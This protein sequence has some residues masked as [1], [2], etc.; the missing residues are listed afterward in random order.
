MSGAGGL[1]AAVRALEELRARGRPPDHRDARALLLELG[2][3]L[4]AAP[5]GAAELELEHARRATEALGEAW[6][7]AALEELALASTE[8]VRSVD[9]RYLDLPNYDFEYTLAARE[10]L[11][12]RLVAAKALGLAPGNR[13][14]RK[15]ERADALL[16]RRLE[17]LERP[18]G[19]R[20][21]GSRGK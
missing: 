14:L 9:P 8:Y 7:T 1:E 10:R 4:L 16:A 19:G 17:V 5:G 13:T 2:L 12:A 21:G 15:V 20:D 18:P 6:L 11:E 3:R